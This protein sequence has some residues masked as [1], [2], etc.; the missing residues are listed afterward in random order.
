[1]KKD[2]FGYYHCWLVWGRF[3]NGEIALRAVCT[4]E[5]ICKRYEAAVGH[6]PGMIA[7]F[8]ESA[9]IN[10]LYLGDFDHKM[11]YA[12]RHREPRPAYGAE[13]DADGK[14]GR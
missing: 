14:E 2:K 11:L 9:R 1:M 5:K 7:A 12:L 13:K 6:E 10:H 4:S 8:T 3:T